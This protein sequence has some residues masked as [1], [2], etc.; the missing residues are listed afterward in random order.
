M[1]PTFTALVPYYQCPL[2]ILPHSFSCLSFLPL[3]CCHVMLDDPP[4]PCLPLC[5]S[6]LVNAHLLQ[7]DSPTSYVFSSSFC[8]LPAIL[9]MQ[10]AYFLTHLQHH[11]HHAYL[12]PYHQCP[13]PSLA[14]PAM[15]FSLCMSC[16]MLSMPA[17]L[18]VCHVS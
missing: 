3:L 5:T 16:L 13:P 6:Y 2:L 8:L 9:Y 12:L 15:F 18:L 7:A 10:D 17:A 4:A 1:L 14:H 11:F